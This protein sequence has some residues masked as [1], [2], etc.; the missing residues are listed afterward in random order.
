VYNMIFVFS[1]TGNSKYVA[2]RIAGRT[3]DELYSMNDAIK[4][5]KMPEYKADENLIIVCP[6]YAWRIPKVVEDWIDCNNF[7]GA[8]RIWFVM[9]CG[10]EIGNA[11]KYTQELADRK[12]YEY[13]GTVGIKMPDNYIIMFPSISQESAD[14]IYATAESK[15]DVVANRLREG[16]EFAYFGAGMTDKIKSSA[17]N[18]VFQKNL[19]AD[20]YEVSGKCTSC[21]KCEKLCP[22]NNISLVDGKPVWGDTCTHCMACI[23]YCP[24]EAI[25][26]GKKTVGKRKYTIESYKK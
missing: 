26:Y 18:A 14:Q 1:G 21:G 15:I 23:S 13:M 4:S 5:G 7:E 24:T 12:G 17:V 25:E 11:G 22:L 3:G 6:T 9:T 8:K 2:E 16:K 19:K 10:G 20:A